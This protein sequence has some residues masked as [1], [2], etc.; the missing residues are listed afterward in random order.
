MNNFKKYLLSLLLSVIMG[1]AILGSASAISTTYGTGQTTATVSNL[2][3]VV[4]SSS[5]E[6]TIKTVQGVTVY[7]YRNTSGVAPNLLRS[8]AYVPYAYT[9]EGITF[10]V[11]VSDPNGE[12][13][14][15]TNG[16]GVD[17]LLVPEGQNP[18]NP[19]YVIHAGFDP[20]TSGD[21]DL[22]T[23]KFYA[24]WTV[25]AGS[26][27]CFDVYVTARDKHGVCTGPIYKGKVFLNPMIGINVTKDNDAT[28]APFTGLSFGNVTPGQQNVSAEENVVSVHNLDP[29]NVGTKVGVFVSA[30]SLAQVGGT[31]IIPAENIEADV[32]KVNNAT[33]HHEITLQNNVKILLFEPLKPGNA[34]ALE[35]NFTLDVPEPLPSGCYGGSITFY[36]IGL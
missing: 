15:Q 36:G 5:Y 1:I 24:Q 28:P 25:P 17:F 19:A 2:P 11:N 27:G 33:I 10:Y 35:V 34:N 23:L 18:A 30:T 22:S 31:G 8:D 21:S 16:A 7:E 32:I 29:D 20:T 26:H 3:P 14:L 4:N 12:Q 13:D 9:G 6:M